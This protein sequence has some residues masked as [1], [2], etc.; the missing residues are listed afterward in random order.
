MRVG[1]VDDFNTNLHLINNVME[2]VDRVR[3]LGVIVDSKLT[4]APHI[5]QVVA[6]AFIRANLINRCF[7]SRNVATLLR[8]FWVYVRPILDRV[9]IVCLV[10]AP[11]WGNKES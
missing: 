1:N 8:A 10:A 7:I 5:D 6:R 9:C 4:F 2:N 11:S 3:D